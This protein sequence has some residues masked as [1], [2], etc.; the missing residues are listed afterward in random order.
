MV[1]RR[2]AGTTVSATDL[3][4]VGSAGPG[5]G[6]S[7]MGG[8]PGCGGRPRWSWWAAGRHAAPARSRRVGSWRGCEDHR[9]GYRPH[10][11]YAARPA[12]LPSPRPAVATP[13]A[14]GSVAARVREPPPRLPPI[15]PPPPP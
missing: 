15:P 3:V 9:C 8:R 13:P 12:L 5:L 1:V 2:V 7:A 4:V 10:G 11:G 6:P 14:L